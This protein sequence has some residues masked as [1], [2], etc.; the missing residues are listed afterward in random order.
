MKKLLVVFFASILALSFASCGGSSN[1]TN[2]DGSASGAESALADDTGGGAAA[3]Y[4]NMFKSGNYHLKAKMKGDGIETTMESYY[5]DGMVSMR[6]AMAGNSSR[7]IFRDNQMYMIDDGSKT[8][9]VMPTAEKPSNEAVKT[10]GMTRTGSGT[11]EFDGRNLPY[12]EYSSEEGGKVQFFL[13]GK[14]LAG[15][16]NII[17]EEGKIDV[18]ISE[19][20]QNVPAD[21]FDVPSGY[22]KAN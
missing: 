15:I 1:S 16:R 5:K 12:E 19:L 11:A 6:M 4:F 14:K 13:D 17:N 20:D 18:I 22:K 9:M 2:N 10:D 21:A 3:A 7:M 8:Y